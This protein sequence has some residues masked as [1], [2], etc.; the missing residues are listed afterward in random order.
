MHFTEN[1]VVV[2]FQFS[3]SY[4]SIVCMIGNAPLVPARMSVPNGQKKVRY[5]LQTIGNEKMKVANTKLK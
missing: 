3:V 5:C 2:Q 4:L 1:K